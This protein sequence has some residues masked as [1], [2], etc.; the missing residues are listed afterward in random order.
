MPQPLA[1]H[2]LRHTRPWGHHLSQFQQHRARLPVQAREPATPIK[3][4]T[5][6]PSAPATGRLTPP[7]DSPGLVHPGHANRATG[8]SGTRPGT[9]ACTSLR[10][11]G[12]L[13]WAQSP[14]AFEGDRGRDAGPLAVHA[15]ATK[16]QR[17]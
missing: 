2:R 3:A 5:V 11:I 7:M 15:P 14:L 10:T 1:Q 6:C 16:D 17:E 13:R 9:T 12:E 4:G 8:G